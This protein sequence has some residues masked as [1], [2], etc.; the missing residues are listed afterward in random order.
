[1]QVQCT[2][3]KIRKRQNNEKRYLIQLILSHIPVHYSLS[4]ES[5]GYHKLTPSC[6]DRPMNKIKPGNLTWFNITANKVL[7]SS[8][9]DKFIPPFPSHFIFLILTYI[10]H[11]QSFSSNVP[12]K[13]HLVYLERLCYIDQCWRSRHVDPFGA[14]FFIY[15]ERNIYC[16]KITVFCETR[17]SPCWVFALQQISRSIC[18]L[19]M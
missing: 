10:S 1:M 2:L 16:T 17:N 9:C 8:T 18:S 3:I 4:R 13:S 14:L 6:P 15:D 12:Q 19:F 5:N 11:F 7:F